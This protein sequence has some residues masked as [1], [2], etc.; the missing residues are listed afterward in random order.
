MKNS[1]ILIFSEHIRRAADNGSQV[2][3]T[4]TNRYI[5]EC[6]PMLYKNHFLIIFSSDTINIWLGHHSEVL[7]VETLEK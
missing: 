1:M 7:V 4:D 6:H 3:I 5:I 2:P